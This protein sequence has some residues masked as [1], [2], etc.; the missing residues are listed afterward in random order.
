MAIPIYEARMLPFTATARP[1][2]QKLESQR[3]HGG[4]RRDLGRTRV[5]A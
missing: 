2:Q 1:T 4:W 5:E 3:R